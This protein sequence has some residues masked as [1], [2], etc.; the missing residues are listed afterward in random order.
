MKLLK[1]M[2]A[3]AVLA[4]MAPA[5]G[6]SNSVDCAAKNNGSRFE[7]LQKNENRVAMLLNKKDSK[8]HNRPRKTYG[9]KTTR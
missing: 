4:F 7:N 5:Y 2:A 1:S 6:A 3:L 8:D 9:D